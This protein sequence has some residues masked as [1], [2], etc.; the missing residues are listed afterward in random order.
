MNGIYLNFLI[1]ELE[2]IIKGAR[3]KRIFLSER[4]VYLDLSN[5]QIV[6]SFIPEAMGLYFQKPVV[7][8]EGLKLVFKYLRGRIIEGL[9]QDGYRPVLRIKLRG[10]SDLSV[11]ISFIRN[12]Q[13]FF[14]YNREGRPDAL[15]KSVLPLGR[16]KLNP[17]RVDREYLSLLLN[18][19]D[20]VK[21]LVD[22]IEGIDRHLAREIVED[23]NRLR[24]LIEKIKSKDYTINIIS[25][26]PLRLSLFQE[27]ISRFTGFNEAF[28]FGI[29]SFVRE[30]E[31]ETRKRKIKAELK[32]LTELK[33]RL[34]V[35]IFEARQADKFRIMGEAILANLK[36]I[37]PGSE[38]AILLNPYN[39]QEE[40]EVIL[41]SKSSLERNAQNYFER[42]KRLKRKIPY[43]EKRLEVIDREIDNLQKG[44][45]KEEKIATVKQK[46]K[47]RIAEHFRRFLTRGG[48]EVLVGKDAKTNEELTFK[49]ARPF[50][51]FFHVRGLPGSHTVLRTAKKK[52]SRYDIYEA[53]AIAAYF[54]KARN[55]RKVPVSYTERKY[56]KKDKNGP[57]GTVIF[58]R[59]EVIFVDPALSDAIPEND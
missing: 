28:K 40:I 52:P 59:E 14:V 23:P 55:A 32:R 8:T 50:D 18:S 13:D 10:A 21:N 1:G 39:M 41:D 6:I 34:E 4:L 45:F 20:R 36:N 53:G 17:E 5:G 48:F 15:F 49:V 43:L 25:I 58:M 9:E 56:L 19:P 37:E 57:P 44:I 54:S 3:I 38:K 26:R 31:E 30:I 29:E 42:Y 22:S 2:S 16:E 24:Q 47:D 46:E 51:I 11:T 27:G 35:E 33:A 12:H 7:R